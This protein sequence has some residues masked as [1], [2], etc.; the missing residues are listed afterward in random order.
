MAKQIIVRGE[1]EVTTLPDFATVRL[2]VEADAASRQ[3]AY[4]RAARL[5]GE[6]DQQVAAH[7]TGISRTTTSSLTVIQRNRW[8]KGESVPTG[9]RASR[10]SEL[11]VTDLE[12][13][14][15]LLAELVEAG[16][17]VAGLSWEV[18]PTNPA[19]DEARRL[20]SEEARRKA[21]TYTAALGV[22]LGQVTWIAEPGL[23]DQVDRIVPMASPI[24]ASAALADEPID[25]TP[26]EIT[27]HAA[28][29]VG[30]D[31]A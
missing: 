12:G 20:A 10:R 5:A 4:A 16:A 18:S 28:V 21:E 7:A 2:T 29:E 23:R 17:A 30:F 11:R 25:P 19:H 13:L 14:G 22:R 24:R 15:A 31:L 27:L 26:G 1:A 9:W 8:K 3:D 6:V